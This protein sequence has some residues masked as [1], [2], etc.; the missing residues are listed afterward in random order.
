[1][2]DQK[3]L[4]PPPENIRTLLFYL[5]QALDERL[6]IFRAGT[7]YESTR[8]SDIRVFVTAGRASH[9]ISSI[10]REL[11]ITR[12]A[13]QISVKKLQKLQLVTLQPEPGNRRDK[14][15]VITAGGERARDFA[16]EQVVRLEIEFSDVV[17]HQGLEIFRKNLI[18]ILEATLA[19]NMADAEKITPSA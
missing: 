14:L 8:P 5:G 11:G 17:G 12:Q 15:V 6:V 4:S 18:A 3:D 1:M 7:P 10:A 9:T 19:N 16:R 13:V 2:V